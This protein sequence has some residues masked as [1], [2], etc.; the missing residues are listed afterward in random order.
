M[1][2]KTSKMEF[3]IINITKE[4]IG[5]ELERDAINPDIFDCP[6]KMRDKF[7]KFNIGTQKYVIDIIKIRVEVK[8]NRFGEKYRDL[9]N[10]EFCVSIDGRNIGTEIIFNEDLVRDNFNIIH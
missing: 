5:L 6:V 7:I 10:S 4:L 9:L 8:E 1:N 2:F 3:P